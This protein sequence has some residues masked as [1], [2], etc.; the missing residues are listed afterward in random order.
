[1]FFK[2]SGLWEPVCGCGSFHTGALCRDLGA[3]QRDL[4][5]LTVTW[6]QP[7]PALPTL[8][9]P[10]QPNMSHCWLSSLPMAGQQPA[11]V[12]SQICLNCWIECGFWFDRRK[13]FWCNKEV[14]K[15]KIR[16]DCSL[17]WSFGG[18]IFFVAFVNIKLTDRPTHYPL[19]S[20]PGERCHLVILYSGERGS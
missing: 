8:T 5:F 4:W 20:E 15:Y 14:V 2:K 18:N 7:S 10:V 16:V 12:A 3:W 6:A 1:M 19:H 9:S 11:A 17:A 13:S